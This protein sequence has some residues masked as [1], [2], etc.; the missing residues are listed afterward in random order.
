MVPKAHAD[1][2]RMRGK[3]VVWTARVFGT[4]KESGKY[5]VASG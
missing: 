4:K 2:H 3:A 1:W 5:L